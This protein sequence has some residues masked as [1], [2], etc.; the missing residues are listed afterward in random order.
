MVRSVKAHDSRCNSVLLIGDRLWTCGWD[1]TVRLFD[2]NNLSLLQT[3]V[4]YHDDAVFAL[5]DAG[6]FVWSAS[7]DKGIV[8]WS[9]KS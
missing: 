5:L 6:G 7:G 8:V 1:T 9:R 4:G 3:L 2:S